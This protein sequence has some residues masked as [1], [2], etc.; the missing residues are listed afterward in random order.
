MTT[1]IADA[2]VGR[3]QER[4]AIFAAL[5][6]AADG[7]GGVVFV[8]GRPGA[9]KSELMARV[10]RDAE[11]DAHLSEVRFLTGPC[12]PAS[13]GTNPHEPFSE[14]LIGLGAGGD[15][16]LVTSI[17]GIVREVAP[18]LLV[19]VPGL[20]TALSAGVKAVSTTAERALQIG[21]ASHGRL[22]EAVAAEYENTLLAIARKHGPL[23]F[24]IEDA[25]W[26]DAPSIDLIYRLA[27]SARSA[28]L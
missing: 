4:S 7:H 1:D 2:F 21:D 5:G 9:G 14:A 10:R 24:V 19:F 15:R 3:E 23:A 13:T 12:S 26:S 17:L 6:H 25:H 11:T 27:S 16:K 8:A 28:P 18:D 22:G 20:G